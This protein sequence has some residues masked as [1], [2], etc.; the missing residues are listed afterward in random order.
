LGAVLVL[1]HGDHGGFGDNGGFAGE[2][3]PS[4]TGL[5]TVL[6]GRAEALAAGLRAVLV[7]RAGRS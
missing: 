6:A 5:R 4:A 1:F 2:P 3:G 7:G